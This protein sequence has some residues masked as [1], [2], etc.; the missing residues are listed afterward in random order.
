MSQQ[1]CA[2]A[3]VPSLART[4]SSVKL[5]TC[6]MPSLK[7]ASNRRAASRMEEL[8]TVMGTEFVMKTRRL[9][10]PSVLAMLGLLMMELICAASAL[11]LSFSI[12]SVK[13]ETGFWK[14]QLSTVASCL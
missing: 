7:I 12:L 4:A 6:L 9:D 1:E 14:I 3:T 11:I 5:G 13:S 8:K 2:S 10:K